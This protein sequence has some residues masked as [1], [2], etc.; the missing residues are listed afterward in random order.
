MMRLMTRADRCRL[1]IKELKN[2]V[3]FLKEEEVYTKEKIM[4][5]EVELMCTLELDA[6]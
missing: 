3:A 2:R 1:E 4:E 5:L 6:E